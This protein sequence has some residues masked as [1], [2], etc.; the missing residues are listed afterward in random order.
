MQPRE[1]IDSNE[2]KVNELTT[3]LFHL[4]TQIKNNATEQW[5][6]ID[7][8][9]E[10]FIVNGRL[11]LEGIHFTLFGCKIHH[12]NF[13]NCSFINCRFSYQFFINCDFSESIFTKLNFN[14]CKMDKMTGSSLPQTIVDKLVNYNA[15]APWE[16]MSYGIRIYDEIIPRDKI[17]Q[18]VKDWADN[19]GEMNSNCKLI[20]LLLQLI[21]S[22]EHNVKSI[23]Q[24]VSNQVKP[25]NYHYDFIMIKADQGF[26][27]FNPSDSSIVKKY[28]R[29]WKLHLSVDKNSVK[30]A[31]NCVAHLLLNNDDILHFK[32]VD[33]SIDESI[34]GH[35]FTNGAQ[36][37]IYLYQDGLQPLVSKER[38]KNL[39]QQMTERLQSV[40][41]NPGE[42]PESDCKTYYPYFSLR[43]DGDSIFEYYPAC[44]VGKNYN[45]YYVH[46][47]FDYLIPE[48]KKL[49]NVEYH[50]GLFNKD[51]QLQIRKAVL[52]TLIAIINQTLKTEHAYNVSDNKIFSKLLFSKKTNYIEIAH[53]NILLSGYV[54]EDTSECDLIILNSLFLYLHE[55][56]S[57]NRIESV[58]HL[59]EKLSLLDKPNFDIQ[60]VYRDITF[61]VLKSYVQDSENHYLLENIKRLNTLIL[62]DQYSAHQ[63]QYKDN[64]IIK[65]D[66]I[67]IFE[68]EKN[69]FRHEKKFIDYYESRSQLFKQFIDEHLGML[70][71]L[72]NGHL[73]FEQLSALNEDKQALL[74][75]HDETISLL[76][77]GISIEAINNMRLDVLFSLLNNLDQIIVLCELSGET[78][79]DLLN[80]DHKAIMLTLADPEKVKFILM[81]FRITL[82]NFMYLPS[83]KCIILMNH[84]YRSHVL[85]HFSMPFEELM[86]LRDDYLDKLMKYVIVNDIDLNVSIIQKLSQQSDDIITVC[87][88]NAKA[89]NEDLFKYNLTIKQF[90]QLCQLFKYF[91]NMSNHID[92]IINQF[93]ISVD[94]LFEMPKRLQT[95]ICQHAKYISEL[96]KHYSITLD[97]IINIDNPKRYD[98]LEYSFDLVEIAKKTN[99]T[100]LDILNAIEIIK[101]INGVDFSD[102]N[103]SKKAFKALLKHGVTFENIFHLSEDDLFDLSCSIRS[104]ADSKFWGNKSKDKH[105]VI[106]EFI[107]KHLSK[108]SRTIQSKKLSVNC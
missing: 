14:D 8:I 43:N 97:D 59:V 17:K 19:I 66:H 58:F 94:Q 54:R 68:K 37:T 51:T 4:L 105:N 20:Q 6:L 57:G 50:F 28:Y 29:G 83:S 108:L 95:A 45:P 81:F 103:S 39:L 100:F 22:D 88:E 92:I 48:E 31:Y 33:L 44:D 25:L 107:T 35:R 70:R 98:I 2:I 46:C 82:N 60:K 96:I 5:C 72:V 32:V 74:I 24:Y 62:S 9:P 78:I 99:L 52:A 38:L 73:T 16:S 36:F 7:E 69:E 77:S 84:D 102:L 30:Q 10:K 86:L 85:N 65:T 64:R 34:R 3:H 67:Y 23:Y 79:L 47:V 11:E 91:Y 76:K 1:V 15:K 41:I 18:T 104:N 27:S 56:K 13:K 87:L 89:L 42:I 80:Q 101:Q 93:N 53:N 55:L 49:F 90:Y 40:D 61:Y 75:Y 71:Q 21:S 12:I 26:Y 106:N 63:I